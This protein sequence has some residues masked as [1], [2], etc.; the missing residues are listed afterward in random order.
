[1]F[2]TGL[3]NGQE[4]KMYHLY[5]LLHVIK[6]LIHLGWVINLLWVTMH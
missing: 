4:V 6:H 5:L 2:V 1:M 3:K